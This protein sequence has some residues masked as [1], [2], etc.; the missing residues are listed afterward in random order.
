MP[1]RRTW[2]VMTTATLNSSA[3]LVRRDSIWPNFCWRSASSPRPEKSTRNVA[4]IE[5]MICD[6]V[7]RILLRQNS[8]PYQKSKLPAIFGKFCC[9]LVDQLHLVFA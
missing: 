9:T 8:D 1:F 5:S 4:I 2:F 3:I 6:R 7:K